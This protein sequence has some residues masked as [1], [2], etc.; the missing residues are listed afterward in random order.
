M[1][2]SHAETWPPNINIVPSPN[3]KYTWQDIQAWLKEARPVVCMVQGGQTDNAIKAL[4]AILAKENMV[5][6]Y[7]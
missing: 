7:S 4:T 2:S 1:L 3:S 5:C 6:A